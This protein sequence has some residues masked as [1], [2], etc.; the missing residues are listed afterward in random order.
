MKLLQVNELQDGM[1]L[2]EDIIGR[3]GTL[4]S[5]S[6]TILSQKAIEGLKKIDIKYVCVVDDV[7][8]HEE[9]VVVDKKLNSEYQRTVSNF[10]DIFLM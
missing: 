1:V 2:A 7:D 10:K 5:A 4:Y 9:A 6:G 8:D 3:F